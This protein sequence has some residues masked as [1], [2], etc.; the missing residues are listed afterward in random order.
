MSNTEIRFTLSSLEKTALEGLK[1]RKLGGVARTVSLHEFIRQLVLHLA[2]EGADAPAPRTA[3]LTVKAGQLRRARKDRGLT[4]AELAAALG[5]PRAVVALW[6]TEARPVPPDQVPAVLQWIRTGKL[7]QP[8]GQA[9][10]PTE[11]R[12]TAFQRIL[13]GDFDDILEHPKR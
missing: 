12:R 3:P 9:G 5:V 13:E 4:Q 11:R 6:E 7:P 2:A 8:S 10:G 1:R